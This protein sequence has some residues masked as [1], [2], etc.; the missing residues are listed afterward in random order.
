MREKSVIPVDEEVE[1][2]RGMRGVGGRRPLEPRRLDD[3]SRNSKLP[4]PK[5]SVVLAR[6]E[7]VEGL[8]VVQPS[9]LA[10]RGP[11]EREEVRTPPLEPE[12]LV[13]KSS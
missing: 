11:E 1:G 7:A 4:Q 3:A 12:S 10:P 2:G 8:P 9:C 13:E 6:S 5:N